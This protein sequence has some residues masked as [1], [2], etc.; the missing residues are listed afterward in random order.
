MK[1]YKCKAC[2]KTF[3]SKPGLAGHYYNNHSELTCKFCGAKIQGG[4]IGLTH[5]IKQKHYRE[6]K[7]LKEQKKK[8][9]KKKGKALKL[10]GMQVIYVPVWLEIS[11]NTMTVRVVEKLEE[12]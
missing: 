6:V 10:E 7:E 12:K 9:Q 5:H 4:K 8:T 3:R 1:H 11:L 2:G